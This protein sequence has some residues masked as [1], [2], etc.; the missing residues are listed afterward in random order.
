MK[1]PNPP[2]RLGPTN[3]PAYNDHSGVITAVVSY[4]SGMDWSTMVRSSGQAL[5]L[6]ETTEPESTT[7][8]TI[9]WQKGSVWREKL[10]YQ[11]Y[12]TKTKHRCPVES[13]EQGFEPRGFLLTV[14]C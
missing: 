4:A 3:L 14:S 7:I 5:L 1:H 6:A 9:R 12:L 8:L 11:L 10:R 2:G 13:T